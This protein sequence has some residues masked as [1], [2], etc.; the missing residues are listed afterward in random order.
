[1]GLTL[2][3][4]AFLLP[5]LSMSE[6]DGIRR[7]RANLQIDDPLT[8]VEE[9]GHLL[10]NHP[11]SSSVAKTCIEALAAAKKEEEAFRAWDCFSFR[12]PHLM[13]DRQ[14]L[15]ELAWCVLKKGLESRQNGVRLASIVGTYLTHDIR[16]VPILKKMMSDSN[17]VIRSVAT[18]MSCTY[19]DAPLKEEITRL[20]KEE[21]VWMVR[22]QAIKA[23]GALKMKE[24]A[25]QLKNIVQ[26]EKVTY[27]ERQLAIEALL[28]I[29]EK[30]SLAEWEI[31]AKSNRAGIRHLACCIASHFDMEEA[32]EGILQLVHDPHPDVRVAALNSFGLFFRK[33]IPANEGLEK[34]K[35]SLQ[36]A[37]PAVGVT[38]AWAAMLIDREVAKA[39]FEKW[40]RDPFP[41]SRRI[42]AA[43]LAAS[44]KNG[45]ELALSI[46]K[47]HEDPYVKANLAL[48][49][50]GQRMEVSLCCNEL[51]S[52]LEG[53]KRM[54]MWDQQLNPLFKVLSPSQV[55]YID[56]IPN[57]PE[58]IDQMTRLNLVSLLAIVE[59]PRAL[60]VLKGFLQKRSWGISG[61]AAA[62]LLQE[63]DETALELVRQL[64][65][66][67]DPN[68]QLQACLVLA[69]LG[70]DSAAF[71]I[72]QKAYPGSDHERKLHILEAV[73]RLGSMGSVPFLLTVFK[74]PFPVL[75]IVAAASLIQCLN[76]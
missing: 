7:V 69:M 71:P 68:I 22:L 61:V 39:P 9:A 66:E 2:G 54:W 16:A 10:E 57:Y 62:T 52:F 20:M 15:E 64:M 26:S 3:I 72:L 28:N 45:R 17:A 53:E 14:L 58:A 4:F 23:A 40:L 12:Y 50:L 75:R 29:Y 60:E 55:R 49:L 56:Q 65:D 42:A 24:L 74:E 51:Y 37:N 27:E 73:G 34:I 63:G 36:D 41:E 38:A 32:Q 43:A 76:R 21:K 46:M 31:L 33:K 19:G 70:K 11:N 59:D 67:S 13:E 5:L 6:E 8:A 30:I 47:E 18:Q 25:P 44:G 1:M 48:G 35:E